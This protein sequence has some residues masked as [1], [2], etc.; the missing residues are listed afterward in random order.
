ML[1]GDF[2]RWAVR[3]WLAED[4]GTYP[5]SLGFVN[6]RNRAGITPVTR[7]TDVPAI[8]DAFLAVPA[9]MKEPPYHVHLASGLGCLYGEPA[10][11][12]VTCYARPYILTGG[13]CAH[14]CLYMASVA[15]TGMNYR[16]P[17]VHEISRL[18]A[19][20]TDKI[21]NDGCFE[22][23][24]IPLDTMMQV[25]N[26]SL[27]GGA[28]V[29]EGHRI[30]DGS[31]KKVGA[32]GM[33]VQEYLRQGLPVILQVD[34][35]KLYPEE[36]DRMQAAYPDKKEFAHVL[37]LIG[38]KLDTVAPQGIA[39]FVYHDSLKG[40]YLERPPTQ[41]LMSGK[42]PLKNS[43]DPDYVCYL[44]P[45][46]RGAACGIATVIDAVRPCLTDGAA[47]HWH[48]ALVGRSGLVDRYFGQL[49]DG[50][51]IR[52]ELRNRQDSLPAWTWVV[53]VYADLGDLNRGLA[54]AAYFVDAGKANPQAVYAWWR[55]E[56]FRCVL[57]ALFLTG[58]IPGPIRLRPTKVMS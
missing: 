9:G 37:M 39:S 3:V 21:G 58:N 19:V 47:S 45:L 53:E 1:G 30:P 34:A 41:L 32:V 40:A 52:R 48:A 36:R 11:P 8:A 20:I 12:P 25:L 4:M 23:E 18:A 46:P 44:V 35:G 14:A 51:S 17:M 55:D 50:H 15:M 56:Q 27:V 33:I 54:C 16:V 31:P 24:G 28:G 42:F 43:G 29:I 38:E 22:V 10:R 6:L 2:R 5:E 7:E 13:V 26:S 57:P 49:P